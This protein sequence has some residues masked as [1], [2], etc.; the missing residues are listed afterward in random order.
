MPH[1][2]LYFAFGRLEDYNV[3]LWCIYFI[4]QLFLKDKVCKPCFFY[5]MYLLPKTICRL[6]LQQG[7]K[8]QYTN[9]GQK[10]KIMILQN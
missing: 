10:K 5:R 9:V 8:I 1:N 4:V 3:L 6:K 7:Q 2:I